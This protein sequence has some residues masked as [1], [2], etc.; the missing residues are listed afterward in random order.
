MPER[1]H[2]DPRRATKESEDALRELDGSFVL[3]QPRADQSVVSFV[4]P[5]VADLMNEVFKRK[6]DLDRLVASACFF[7]QLEQAVTWARTLKRPLV[8]GRLA[9]TTMA[10]KMVGLVQTKSLKWVGNEIPVRRYHISASERF[11]GLAK[12]WSHVTDPSCRQTLVDAAGALLVTES[13]VWARVRVL[14]AV[15]PFATREVAAALGAQVVGD[16]EEDAMQLEDLI[17]LARVEPLLP[18]HRASQ[19]RA[20][21]E[22]AAIFILDNDITGNLSS[23]VRNY[24]EVDDYRDQV[25]AVCGAFGIDSATYLARIDDWA[26]EQFG[27]PGD[28]QH[29]EA[30]R[31]DREDRDDAAA[32]LDDFFS[33]LLDKE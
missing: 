6:N 24:D 33:S 5:S 11:A 21:S 31:E 19:R 28:D 32:D 9:T 23:F 30:W 26:A 29:Y 3:S 22:R 7:D 14:E 25:I 8:D 12:L 4:N 18:A 17:A 2:C 20:E 10:Q 27:D 1:A 16:V 15:L 13:D